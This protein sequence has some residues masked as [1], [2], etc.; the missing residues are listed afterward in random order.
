MINKIKEYFS[1][2]L[3]YSGI[4]YINSLFSQKKLTIVTFHRIVPDSVKNKSPN[5]S[6]ML[7][8]AQFEDLIKMISI[9]SNPLAL[10]TAVLYFKTK[11][12]FPPRSIVITFDDGYADNYTNAYPILKKYKIP[13]TVYIATKYINQNDQWFWWEEVEYFFKQNKGK[14]LKT[15]K[16]TSSELIDTINR[17]NLTQTNRISKIRTFIHDLYKISEKERKSLITFM[18]GKYSHPKTHLMLKWDQ[19]KSMTDI[20]K[21]GSHTVNHIFLNSLSP[22]RISDEFTQSKCLIERKVGKKC[23]SISYPAG[24]VSSSVIKKAIESGYDSGVTSKPVNNSLKTN[25]YLLNRK[26]AGYFFVNNKLKKAYFFFVLSSFFDLFE[27][28]RYCETFVRKIYLT[29]VKN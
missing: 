9:Y 21:I 29:L 12:K 16:F 13:A 27:L 11:K 2:I 5:K 10:E 24:F 26:D 3:F 15:A 4:L 18:R 20:F 14:K 19:V 6:M 7:T 1:R 8:V 25:I 28:L 17:L 23:R 22:S